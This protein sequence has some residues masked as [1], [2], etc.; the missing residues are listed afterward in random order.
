MEHITLQN[1]I[2]DDKILYKKK[3]WKDFKKYDVM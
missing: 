3:G 2:K 1:I